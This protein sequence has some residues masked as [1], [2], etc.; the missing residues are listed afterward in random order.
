MAW[1]AEDNLGVEGYVRSVQGQENVR[2]LIRLR[3][4]SAGLLADKKIICRM[5]SDQRC[6]MCDN[7]I[8]QDVAHFLVGCGEI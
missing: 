5:V 8:G 3:T 7:G 6:V 1:V 2:L 4:D